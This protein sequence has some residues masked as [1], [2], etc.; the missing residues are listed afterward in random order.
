[1]SLNLNKNTWKLTS[2]LSTHT[3]YKHTY[4]T[5]LLAN[6]LVCDKLRDKFLVHILV[7]FRR[8]KKH[9]NKKLKTL[10]RETR[11]YRMN[12]TFVVH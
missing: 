6:K 3:T 10:N 12:V 4:H 2:A 9:K 5:Y 7:V 11:I 1:M 8:K